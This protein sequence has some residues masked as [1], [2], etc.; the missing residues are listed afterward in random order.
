MIAAVETSKGRLCRTFP[1]NETFLED[2]PNESA[3][4]VGVCV[5]ARPEMKQPNSRNHIVS[6]KSSGVSVAA[7]EVLWCCSAVVSDC[8][9]IVCVLDYSSICLPVCFYVHLTVHCLHDG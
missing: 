2:F 5:L 1:Q 3:S 4:S 7:G 8:S 9:L 6:F